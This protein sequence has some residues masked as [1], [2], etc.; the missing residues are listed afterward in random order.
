[1]NTQ[2][3]MASGADECVLHALLM[4]FIHQGSSAI[5]VKDELASSGKFTEGWTDLAPKGGN[6][7]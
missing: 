7:H 5:L 3:E 6:L 4:S 2:Q 1:M